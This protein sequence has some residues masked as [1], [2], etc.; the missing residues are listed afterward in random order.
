[1][2]LLLETNPKQKNTG[3]KNEINTNDNPLYSNINNQ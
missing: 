3:E 2:I 1:M